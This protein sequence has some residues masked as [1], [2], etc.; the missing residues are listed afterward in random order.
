MK[1]IIKFLTLVLLSGFISCKKD[2]K[3]PEP[4]PAPTPSSGILKIEFEN[5]VD[6]NP[7]V[8][9]QNFVN[10]KGDTVN[11]SKFNYYIS[12]IVI[13][14]N[15]N[16]TFVE[17]NSYHLVEAI[18]P[19]TNVISLANVPEGSY[20]SISFMLGVDSARNCSG[21]QDGDLDPAKD[22]S[23][24]WSTGYIMVKIEGISPKSSSFTKSLTYH[25]GGYGGVNK[26]Q[27]NFNF[28]FASTTANVSKTVTPMIHLS[29]N[30][31]EFFKTPNLIDVVTQ[32]NQGVVGPSAK[33]YADN[34]ADMISF[35]HVHN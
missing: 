17:P 29:V 35:E 34:Y 7:L 21:A 1:V 26:T 28:N 31:M 2:T 4:E 9:N 15:D 25:I 16:S 27:R 22:M 33:V 14:K 19:S 23:W 12:N 11:I 20:K 3:S 24:G 5:L 8:L 13:T 18:T 32:F 30:I 6:T 10:P